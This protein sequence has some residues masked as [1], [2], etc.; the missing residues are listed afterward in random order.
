MKTLKV[1]F[2]IMLVSATILS[3]CAATISYVGDTMTPTTNV[4]VFYAAK[5]V[6]KEYKV[7]GHL[8][9]QT[10]VN[11]NKAKQR[12]IDKAKKI[13]ADGVIIIGVDFTG[14]SDSTPFLKS[15]AI[16]YKNQ[17]AGL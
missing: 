15:E 12:I 16:K 9:T 5:D 1:N 8:F 11:E 17:A 6:K 2:L 3:S 13:G 10:T 14:G 7:I 4:D